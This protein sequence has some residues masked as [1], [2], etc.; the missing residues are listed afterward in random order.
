VIVAFWMFGPLAVIV[1]GPAAL[2]QLASPALLIV[3]LIE[4]DTVHF[5]SV[6]SG[7][8][9]GGQPAGV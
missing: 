2:M 9:V 5:K 3:T 7:P 8:G 4:S 6:L 1:T